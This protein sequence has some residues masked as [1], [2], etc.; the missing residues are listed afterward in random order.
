MKTNNIWNNFKEFEKIQNPYLYYPDE[1]KTWRFVLQAHSRGRS[2]HGDLRIEISDQLLI[3]YTLDWIKSLPREPK[4]LKD[5]KQLLAKEMPSAWKLM[6]DPLRKIVTQLKAVEP[7]PWLTIDNT[8][9]E[10]GHV[11]ATKHKRGYMVVIDKGTVEF[12]AL[13]PDFREYFFHGKYMPKDLTFRLLPNVWKK[14]S[15]H[16]GEPSKTGEKYTVWQ[17][18]PS[19]NLEPY[20]ISKRAVKKKWYPPKQISAL[21]Q[22][23]R[24]QVKSD[25]RYWTVNDQ[26]EAHRVRD[27]LVSKLTSKQVSLTYMEEDLNLPKL[28]GIYIVEPHA[29]MIASGS[30]QLIIKSKPFFSKLYTEMYLLSGSKNYGIIILEDVS[31]I[32]QKQ[33]KELEREHLITEEE[34]DKWWDLTNRPKRPLYKFKFKFKPFKVPLDVEIPHGVQ[35]FV[36]SQNIKFTNLN[37]A[38]I[39]TVSDLV[40]SKSWM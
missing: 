4:D 6:Q 1:N 22:K 20:V 25:L 28:P 23:I 12:G 13:R 39:E 30:K 3:G 26:K 37:P 14:L 8:G 21:P 24:K 2:V 29:K 19:K 10:K 33:F 31:E 32:T 35:T 38:I 17:C 40:K 36:K 16:E 18:F 27:T 7:H 5:A 15:I 34:A 11:G 9:F